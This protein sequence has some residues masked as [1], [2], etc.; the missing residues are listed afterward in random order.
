MIGTV[1]TKTITIC[2]IYWN[3]VLNEEDRQYF[4][5]RVK[6]T[7]FNLLNNLIKFTKKLQF[8]YKLLK[9]QVEWP[10]YLAALEEKA[11]SNISLQKLEQN[12]EKLKLL[13][14]QFM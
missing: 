10:T 7:S 11:S 9:P 3:D 8:L 5:Q 6:Q 12:E 2:L 13:E 14:E 4:K 1:L